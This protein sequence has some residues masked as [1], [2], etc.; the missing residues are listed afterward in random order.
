MGQ[1]L[2]NDSSRVFCSANPFTVSE[3][4]NLHVGN[5]QISLSGKSRGTASLSHR[6]AGRLDLCQISYGAQARIVSTGLPEIYHVHFILRGHCRYELGRET[7]SLPAG[8]TLLIN[9]NDHIDLTY[10]EDCEKFIVRIPSALLHEVCLEHHWFKPNERITFNQTPYT[11]AELNSLFQ[12]L[13]LL[14][15]EVESDHTTPQL[16]Q[17]Y[18]R[19]VTGKLMTM[20]KHNVPLAPHPTTNVSFERLVQYIDDNIK[21]DIAAEEL[22]QYAKMSLRS[23]Y[24]LFEKNTHS[25]PKQFVRQKKLEHVYATLIHPS[26]KV[27]NVTA[28]ALDYGFTHLGRFSEL[29]KSTFG[30]LPSESLKDRLCQR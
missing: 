2:L 6:K 8:H 24:N 16:L 5:H 4:V 1:S 13:Q 26:N 20:L 28:I 22:A 17:Y 30:V 14:C 10:S 15:T 9:P 18:N 3:Y 12:L 29:Y 19:V 21:R 11:F 27:T 23:L 25:T 7:L